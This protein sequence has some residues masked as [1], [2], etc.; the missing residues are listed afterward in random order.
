MP[1]KPERTV[2]PGADPACPPDPLEGR[3]PKLRMGTVRFVDVNHE[4]GVELAEDPP[5]IMRG[6][7]FRKSMP[8]ERGMLFL[9]EDVKDQGFWMK[10]TCIPLD[11]LYITDDGL[12]VG[13]EENVPTLTLETRSCGCPSHYVLEMNA[14][15]ARRHGVKPGQR[16]VLGL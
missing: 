2:P 5:V 7:M 6:L 9:L 13:I 15:W 1:A 3:E 16:V 8:E 11:M 14:G 10:N 12:I 4:V